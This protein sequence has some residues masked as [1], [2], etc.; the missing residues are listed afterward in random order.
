MRTMVLDVTVCSLLF[1]TFQNKHSRVLNCGVMMPS[2]NKAAFWIEFEN[3][4]FQQLH[5]LA[6]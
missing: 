6:Y 2:T 4:A 3:R 1:I 5:F